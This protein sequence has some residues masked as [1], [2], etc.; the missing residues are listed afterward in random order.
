MGLVLVFMLAFSLPAFAVG[1]RATKEAK[2]FNVSKWHQEP[3]YIDRAFGK[4]SYGAWNFLL[5]WTELLREPY[6]AAVLGKNIPLGVVK[7]V[8]F[9]AADT[10]VGLIHF[11]TFPITALDIPMPQGGVEARE[12]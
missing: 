10:G 2:E 6:E 5:G 8:G 7:G 1:Y 9:A 11:F 12:F 3:L 4:L